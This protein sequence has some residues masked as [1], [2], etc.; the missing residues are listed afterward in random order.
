MT[1]REEMIAVRHRVALVTTVLA[2]ALAALALP[3]R[4]GAAEPGFKVTITELPA[5]FG[6]GADARTLTVVASTD[7]VRCR[8]VR[9]S[10]V[11]QVTGAEVDEVDV[12]RVEE[13]GEFPVRVQT[14][15]DVARITDE[16]L[17]PGELCRGRTVTARYEIGFDDDAGTGRVIFQPQAFDAA[18][19]LLQEASGQ[20]SVVGEDPQATESPTDSPTPSPSS[21]SEESDDAEYGDPGTDPTTEPEPAKSRDAIGAVPASSDGGAPSLLGPGL[22]VGAVLVFLGVA[23]LLRLRMRNRD[24]RHGARTSFYPTR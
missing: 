15:D 22:I 14:D 24:S 11:M 17:D 6:A 4:A 7:R 2:V 20:S 19:T 23:L 8:K 18:G 1:L 3:G 12:R 9:W 21:S 10:L 13:T 16:Q 5:S